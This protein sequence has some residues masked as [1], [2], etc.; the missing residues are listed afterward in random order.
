MKEK[1]INS[2]PLFFISNPR[3]S[4]NIISMHDFIRKERISFRSSLKIFLHEDVQSLSVGEFVKPL[5]IHH[6]INYFDYILHIIASNL[7]YF[8]IFFRLGIVLIKRRRRVIE[9]RVLHA[10]AKDGTKK[11]M[12][13]TISI[14]I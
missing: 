4:M 6:F 2:I 9:A 1:L 8:H 12:K 10:S 13:N 3:P 11:I 7:H 14:I 5:I